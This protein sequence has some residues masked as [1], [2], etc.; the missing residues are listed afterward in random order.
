MNQFEQLLKDAESYSIEELKVLSQTARTMFTAK[1]EEHRKSLDV[2]KLPFADFHRA[3]A[4]IHGTTVYGKRFENW[5]RY[6]NGWS[7]PKSD[8]TDPGDAET[9]FGER[10]EV[11]Y[12]SVSYSSSRNG[13]ITWNRVQFRNRSQHYL[14]YAHEYTKGWDVYSFYL[15][16]EQALSMR[17]DNKNS[18]ITSNF[19]F[20]KGTKWPRMQEFLIGV[21][22]RPI[23]PEFLT[24]QNKSAKFVA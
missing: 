21:S 15:T 12:A 6:Q 9:S 18:Q 24:T 22:D 4:D 1:M 10:V 23:V 7:C 17:D 3:Y 5:M 19:T 8:K 20:R 13:D 2:M 16:K 14:L 11:K